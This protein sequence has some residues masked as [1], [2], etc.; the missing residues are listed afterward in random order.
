MIINRGLGIYFFDDRIRFSEDTMNALKDPKY[1]HLLINRK[2]KHLYIRPSEKR[3]NDT[4]K[5]VRHEDRGGMTYRIYSKGFV[6]YLAYL[7]GVPYPFNSVWYDIIMQE[8]GQTAFVD[9]KDYHITPYREE[10]L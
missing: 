5:V 10:S 6:K 4:F 2:E 8:E 3:D 9:L 1:I 7:I